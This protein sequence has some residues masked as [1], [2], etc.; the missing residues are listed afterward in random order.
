MEHRGNDPRSE[1]AVHPLYR[2]LICLAL[3]TSPAYGA[4]P[5]RAPPATRV[6][7]LRA[8][9][10][11]RPDRLPI[12]YA[13]SGLT[14]TLRSGDGPDEIVV[15]LRTGDGPLWSQRLEDWRASDVISVGIG[16]LDAAGGGPDVVLSRYSGGQHCCLQ[17][18][19]LSHRGPAW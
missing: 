14:L 12:S 4:A 5:V 18:V 2:I 11:A 16:R 6:I 8:A 17:I 9:T 3:V 13:S 7:A 19:V 10:M 15:E 1:R